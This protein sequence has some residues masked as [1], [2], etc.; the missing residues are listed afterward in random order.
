MIN[1]FSYLTTDLINPTLLILD[2]KIPSCYQIK[3]DY[4]DEFQRYD[5]FGTNRECIDIANPGT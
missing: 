2:L 5:F 3:V 4:L 1:W